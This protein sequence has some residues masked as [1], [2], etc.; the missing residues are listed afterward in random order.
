M[1]FVTFVFDQ[2]PPAPRRVLEVGCGRDG[3]LVEQLAGRGYDAL[4]VDPDAPEGD[5]FVR[6]EFQT[7]DGE[8]DAVV[9]GR[10]LHHVNPLDESLDKLPRLPPPPPLPPVPRDLIHPP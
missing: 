2:L 10:M 4:G 1:D 9:A 7:L 6:A 3:G 5:R 8:W